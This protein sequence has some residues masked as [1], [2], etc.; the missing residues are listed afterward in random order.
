[1][2]WRTLSVYT[3]LSACVLIILANAVIGIGAMVGAW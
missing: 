1:M 3:A 2:S